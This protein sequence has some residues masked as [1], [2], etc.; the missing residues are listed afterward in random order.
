MFQSKH[1]FKSF[2]GPGLRPCRR[3]S[4][5]RV[6][7]LSFLVLLIAASAASIWAQTEAQ[8]ESDEVK[9]VGTHI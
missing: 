4:T 8:I 2:G 3:V 1:S 9:R 6:V 5:R 7:T